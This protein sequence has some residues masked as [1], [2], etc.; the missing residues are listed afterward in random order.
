MET[1]T[2]DQR[3]R[4]KSFRFNIGVVFNAVRFLFLGCSIGYLYKRRIYLY[5]IAMLC[6]ES[7]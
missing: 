2:T 3:K 5:A 6:K 4:Q 7:G 1:R